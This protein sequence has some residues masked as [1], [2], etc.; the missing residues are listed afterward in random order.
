[1]M[2]TQPLVRPSG[3]LARRPSKSPGAKQFE[4]K[5]VSGRR[6]ARRRKN[7]AIR[8][9]RLQEI[10]KGEGFTKGRL[11]RAAKLSPAR[12]RVIANARR[13]LRTLIE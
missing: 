6:F 1:M 8:F 12:R 3:S 4:K 2:R 9:A 13:V 5:K 11:A 7:F 10:G